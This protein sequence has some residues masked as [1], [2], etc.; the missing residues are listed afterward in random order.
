MTSG[1]GRFNSIFVVKINTL[2][3]KTH[4]W[5]KSTVHT[6][7][8]PGICRRYIQD[9]HT[10]EDVLQ[11]S[12]MAG[13]QNIH[14]L[15]DEQML[16]A[17]LKKIVVNNALQYLRKAAKKLFSPK[18]LQK[19]LKFHSLWTTIPKKKLM[20]S[21]MISH[22]KNCC[23]LLTVFLFTINPYLIYILWNIILTLKLP[24]SWE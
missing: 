23:P 3:T 6:P 22:R 19:S 17:W 21:P 10:A 14:Q 18:S 13:I 2:M 4:D 24:V 16:F 8:T 11:D 1:N 7:K 5:Q 9:I 20:F 15:K 12:F